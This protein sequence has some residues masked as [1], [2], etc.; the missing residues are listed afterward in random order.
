MSNQDTL[1]LTTTNT[2]WKIGTHVPFQKNIHNTIISAI[3][4]NMNALQFFLGSP[5]SYRRRRVN[6]PLL[7]KAVTLAT[8]HG[9]CIYSHIPYIYNLTGQKQ[10]CA[11]DGYSDIDTKVELCLQE[12]EYELGILSQFPTNGVVIHPGNHIDRVKGLK[13]I[14]ASINKLNM[15][16]N[17][18]LLLEN[19]AGEGTKLGHTL[20]ELKVILDNVSDDKQDN[21]NVCLDTAHIHGKGDYDLTQVSEVERLF[22][23]SDT[24]LGKGKVQLIHLN[25]SKVELGSKKDRHELIGKGYIWGRNVESLYRLIEMCHERGIPVVMETNPSDMLT[26]MSLY[27]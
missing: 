19:S 26:M 17:S 15:P 18:N 1:T 10:K 27:E 7:D 13:T 23:D 24:I 22:Q 16:P 8:Q 5:K 3:N 14:A 21:V 6:K 12:L 9:T 2:N 11:W 4:H 25:D 20:E